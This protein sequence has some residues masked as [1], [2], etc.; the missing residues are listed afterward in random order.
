[1]AEER[2]RDGAALLN[3]PLLNKG[4]A[5]TEEERQFLGLRGLLPPRV[6][7][8]EQQ[9]LRVL[10]NVRAQSTD[11]DKYVHLMALHDRNRTLFYKV[12]LDNIEEL[13]PVIYTPTVG[14]AC[15]VYAHIYQRPRGIFVSAKD[16]GRIPDLLKNWPYRDLQIIVVT[17]GERILGLGDLGADGMGIP[18][19]KLALYSTCAGIHPSSGLAVTLDVGTE[20]ETLLND[21][22]YIGTKQRRL[23]GKAYDDLVDEFV[24]A[25]Q[26]V[27]P[28]ALI[29]FEDFA[30][31]NAFRF[32]KK[33]RERICM[34][35]DDIQGTAAV[36]LAGLY[37]SLRIKG[38]RLS[39]Q[40]ILFL[41]AGEA[42]TGIGDLIVY[43]MMDEGLSEKEARNS[44]WFMDSRGLVVKSRKDLASH[45]IPYAHDHEALSVFLSAV[46][47]LKP[48]AIIGVSGKPATF[49]RPVLEAMARINK[50]P[51]VFALSNPTSRSECTA[52]EAYG[53]TRGR[54]IF[55]SGS[56]FGPVT[57]VG[58]T[59][60]PAQGNNVYIFPGVGLG[61]VSSRASHV[62]DEMF[63]AAARA[64]AHQ[65][66]KP[67]L[68]EG[69]IYPPLMRIRNV[70]AACAEAVAGVAY[71]RGLAREPRP[72]DLSAFIRSR[73][74]E[75]RYE[76]YV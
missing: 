54:A 28:H 60:F 39:D 41:G 56:P 45:K 74:Y 16:R 49:T 17:D 10:E 5:F 20:N 66:S 1:M 31:I 21:P 75:P 15:Q 11:L 8:L 19:G 64:L 7:S 73:M 37:S 70:S 71:K 68:K 9:A 55:A 47:S 12:L 42:G 14:K 33:Y 58:K 62:T 59:L 38:G 50:R 63:L 43:A 22:L 40:K 46:E 3:D 48:T 51:I 13:I 69:R 44:C 24:L 35:N 61:A 76:S 27:F 34:F 32:L 57:I 29:Q 18:V 65:V 36:T 72:R 23:R 67:D 4:I 26:E 30:T 2:V 53:W 6:L 52:E 25:V